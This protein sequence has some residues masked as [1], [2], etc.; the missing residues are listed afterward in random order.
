MAGFAEQLALDCR[1][2]HGVPLEP[3]T[4]TLAERIR[5]QLP[6]V[7]YIGEL[8]A[9]G[10]LQRPFVSLIREDLPISHLRYTRPAMVAHRPVA[11][12]LN[13][14][15]VVEFMANGATMVVE[16]I[17]RYVPSVRRL[18][19]QVEG[20]FGHPVE[21]NLYVTPRQA[22]GFGAHWDVVDAVL[23]QLWG[24]KQWTVYD[25]VGKENPARGGKVAE[26]AE[27]TPVLETTLRAG[28]ILSI[29]R[30]YPHSGRATGTG[31]MHITLSLNTLTVGTALVALA[32]RLFGTEGYT[33]ELPSRLAED[34]GAQLAAMLSGAQALRDAIGAE[35]T[36]LPARLREQLLARDAYQDVR[37]GAVLNAS[38][39]PA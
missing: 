34:S 10:S 13:V 39:A 24:E 5:C 27:M 6:D 1:F 11:E 26:T 25:R 18:C 9:I 33:M 3:R 31:S 4:G 14:A 32:E 2:E 23:I 22:Q 19:H 8:L 37:L 16:G 29:P 12:V 15:R 36:E 20:A 35:G 7:D 38:A 28:D 30:G 21:A 17:D